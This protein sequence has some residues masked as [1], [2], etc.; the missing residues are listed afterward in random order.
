[1]VSARNLLSVMLQRW[2][3]WNIEYTESIVG[4][5]EINVITLHI[6]KGFKI[7]VVTCYITYVI[8]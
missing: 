8:F 1:M 6:L 2:H 3:Q 7:N 4:K 5:D